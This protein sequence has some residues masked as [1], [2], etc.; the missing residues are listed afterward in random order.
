MPWPVG[1]IAT[2]LG[3]GVI[4]SIVPPPSSSIHGPN[5]P[6]RRRFSRLGGRSRRARG[7]NSIKITEPSGRI[8]L[9]SRSERQ[10]PMARRKQVVE[11]AQAPDFV[12][13]QLVKL[14]STPPAG[15]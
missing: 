7:R 4:V 6:G 10:V 12:P 11:Q 2:R 8:L 9:E 15:D 1:N 13:F 3:V 5:G 14:V